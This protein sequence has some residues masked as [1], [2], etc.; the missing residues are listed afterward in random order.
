MNE[1]KIRNPEDLDAAIVGQ[2]MSK[3]ARLV[4]VAEGRSMSFTV[5][6]MLLASFAM[7]VLGL[8]GTARTEFGADLI[9]AFMG[10]VSLLSALV[11]RLE[12]QLRAFRELQK[13]SEHR[14]TRL[15]RTI[16]ADR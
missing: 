5:S 2:A 15:E 9:P 10:T 4:K 11:M 14:V 7:L 6:V 13:R 12:T 8:I 16:F 1:E 3:Q